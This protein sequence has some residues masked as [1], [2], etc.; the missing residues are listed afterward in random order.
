M[1]VDGK[2]SSGDTDELDV[3]RD[4]KRVA[5]V[6]EGLGQYYDLEQKTELFSLNSGRTW[7][8]MGVN[9]RVEEPRKMPVSFI[10]VDNKPHLAEAGL[11][12]AAIKA[13]RLFVVTTN[14]D[15]PAFHVKKTY[16]NIKVIRYSGNIDFADLMRRLRSDHGINRLTVQTGGSLNTL[17]MRRNLIDRLSIIVA[18]LLVGGK[19][20]PTLMDGESLHSTSELFQLKALRLASCRQL[21]HSYLRETSDGHV[22]G[23]GGM[24]G[25]RKMLLFQPF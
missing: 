15:H 12:Y 3:D 4:W 25:N 22:F 16:P 1:S 7:A 21:Q 20:T 14:S 5:G 6:K 17:L 18:P 8:K 23:R 11:R 13:K 19:S 9:D 2:I 24:R 10:I